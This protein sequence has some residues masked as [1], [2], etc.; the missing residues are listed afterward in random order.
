MTSLPKYQREPNYWLILSSMK[1][2]SQQRLMKIY[3]IKYVWKI[4]ENYAPNCGIELAQPNERL[5]RK[6]KIQSLRPN[7]RRGIQTLRYYSFQI[8]GAQLSNSLPK[9]VRFIQEDFKEALD[10]YLSYVLDEFCS[11]RWSY[12]HGS[13][14]W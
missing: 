10:T 5:G 14:D 12:S 7:T 1:M 6:C 13:A 9:H 11:A 2:S 4:F 8:T 3:R